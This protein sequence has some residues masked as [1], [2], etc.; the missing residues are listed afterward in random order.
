M[1]DTIHLKI[2]VKKS[3]I[4]VHLLFAILWFALCFLSYYWDRESGVNNFYLI[5]GLVYLMLILAERFRPF[6]ILNGEAIIKQDPFPRKVLFKDISSIKN[7]AGDLIIT[8][9]KTE[10]VIALQNMEEE[11]QKELIKRLEDLKPNST[12]HEQSA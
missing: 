5:M 3:K 4:H 10:L 2:P 8:T 6:V 12:N 9:D 7:F 11:Q 1:K